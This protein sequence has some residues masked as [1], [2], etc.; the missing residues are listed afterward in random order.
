MREPPFD[1]PEVLP[2]I[3]ASGEVG[4]SEALSR[5]RPDYQIGRPKDPFRGLGLAVNH[6]MSKPAYAHVKFNEWSQVLAGQA[7]RG[8]YIFVFDPQM[9]VVGMLGWAL[10]DRDTAEAWVE[11]RFAGNV[12]GREGDCILF[13]IWSAD[14]A[15]AARRL[16][17]ASRLIGRGR[18]ASYHRRVYPDGRIRPVRIL[19]NQFV[20]GHIDRARGNNGGGTPAADD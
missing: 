18:Y 19:V 10:T 5:R 13:N 4:G 16:L 17:E 7:R 15:I 1:T 6:L 8:H 12:D 2:D 14:S 9:R 3:A 11:G 20:D